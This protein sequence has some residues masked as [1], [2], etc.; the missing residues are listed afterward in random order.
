MLL[1]SKLQEAGL[2]EDLLQLT[3]FPPETT[4]SVDNN[5]VYN[6][7]SLDDDLVYN[8][9]LAKNE[10][11]QAEASLRKRLSQLER[12]PWNPRPGFTVTADYYEQRSGL[13]TDN[14]ASFRHSQDPQA[15][16]IRTN[17]AI[18]PVSGFKES[19]LEN[20]RSSTYSLV[21]AET[22]SGKSTQVPQ[23]I[24]DDAIDQGIG[25]QCRVLCVQPRRL[26]AQLLARRVA[27]ER[28]EALGD[29]VGYSVR[30]D[31]RF[32]AKGGSI[33][34]CTTG[35]MLNYLK[36]E[37]HKSGSYTHILLDEVHVRDIG[38]DFVMLLLKR[39]VDHCRKNDLPQPKVIVMSATIDVDL[40]SSYFR[41]QGPDGILLP[42]PH[43][44]IPG[45][46]YHVRW[47]FLSEVLEGLEASIRPG[48]LSQLLSEENTKEFLRKQQLRFSCK[49]KTEN[50]ADDIDS[51]LG[52]Q[53]AKQAS[54][55]APIDLENHVDGVIPY[56][57][58]AGLV[59]HLF[60]TT[61]TGAIL[62]FLPGLQHILDTKKT[63]FEFD[64]MLGFDFADSDRFR[65]LTLHSSLPEEQEELSKKF[66]EGCRR[67]ILATDIAEASLTI[68]D[69][70]YVID[71]GRV[72]RLV[73]N[74]KLRSS[75]VDC[76]WISQS[77]ASQRA[78]RAGRVHD[79]HYYFVGTNHLFHS[80][81]VTASPEFLRGDLQTT[82]LVA[83][84]IVPDLSISEA[85]Q[86]APEP[87]DDEKILAAVDSLKWLKALDENENL[88]S[89]GR[90]LNLL[91]LTPAFGKLVILG[92]IF[93]C[94]DPLL[95][96]AAMGDERS[97]FR[98]GLNDDDHKKILLDR[99]KYA[100][101]STSDH[102]SAVNAFQA[103]RNEWRQ[104]DPS[105][106]HALAVSNNI[107]FK[108]Y[109]QVFNMS[110]HIFENLVQE[111]LV[112]PLPGPFAR[113][114][115]LCGPELNTN[116]HNVP[117]IKALLLHC[118]TPQIAAARKGKKPGRKY[119]TQTD[120]VATFPR[121]SLSLNLQNLPL[122]LAL[123]SSK[124][125]GYNEMRLRDVSLISPL[126]ACVFGGKL[127]W[128]D[129]ELI[130][131]SWLNMGMNLKNTTS[132]KDEVAAEMIQFSSALDK[133]GAL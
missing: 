128:Q 51:A 107:H 129:G 44:S 112:F 67:I 115:T 47:H 91:P 130:V 117:L 119:C 89:V 2:W 1:I 98:R 52:V 24:L 26:A 121:S 31:S 104:G 102:L 11:L 78:G 38:I 30:F 123:Y 59:Y 71:G 29:S 66:P 41:N 15:I 110:R 6:T 18:L 32:P 10:L 37:F 74:N 53:P 28:G 46:Q 22:G 12:G 131:N 4:I 95:V 17:Q 101:H 90:I 92:V 79:G 75:R 70:R 40:F 9:Q 113:E 118:L 5:L 105:S 80:L 19:I 14:L 81:R 99:A 76:G 93:R 62:V 87:P 85:L 108:R 33:T 120:E 25:G 57:L 109:L 122:A 20:I 50:A 127:E 106:A 124:A 63:L 64:Q 39:H 42:A 82:S 103:V 58:I 43:I 94:L 83:K 126:A 61:Q 116:S 100:G 125:E 111:R 3:Y 8:M 55:E 88:T 68:P 35:I 23:M 49:V 96:I 69:V 132:S 27:Y 84:S 73:Y 36:D 56:G 114:D 60:K 16:A 86:Q 77:S 97:I 21:V 13:L 133:V 7:I 72:N 65:I 34:Y 48:I 54:L 45:R